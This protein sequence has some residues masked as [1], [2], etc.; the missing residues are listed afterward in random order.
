MAYFFS[1][2]KRNCLTLLLQNVVDVLPLTQGIKLLK[3][4]SL[5]LDVGG[6][7]TPLVIMGGLT[8]VCIAVSF[9]LFK[10]E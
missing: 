6:L 3:G 2:V 9:R 10:W 4:F 8:V 1:K 7:L 5:G